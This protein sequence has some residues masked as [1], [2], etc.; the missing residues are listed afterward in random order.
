M[1]TAEIKEMPVNERI[2]LMEEIWDSLCHE[3]KEIESPAWH[4]EILD[5]RVNLINSGKANFIS[6]QELKDANT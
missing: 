1:L 6:I 3:G 2:I 5:E 4:K